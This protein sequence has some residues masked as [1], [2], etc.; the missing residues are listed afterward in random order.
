MG[1]KVASAIDFV[2]ASGRP[3]VIAALGE[4]EAALRGRAGTTITAA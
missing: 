4:V 3:A 1:P 2:V